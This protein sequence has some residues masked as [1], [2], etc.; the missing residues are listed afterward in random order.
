MLSRSPGKFTAK[1][2]YPAPGGA[3][4]QW[5]IAIYATPVL[6]PGQARAGAC[7][8]DLQVLAGPPRD[9]DPGDV[10]FVFWAL[11]ISFVDEQGTVVGGGHFGLQWFTAG[12]RTR[13]GVVN[14][15]VYD[16]LIGDY[17]VFR[18]S[19]PT[20]PAFVDIGVPPSWGVDYE[21]GDWCRF[22]CFRSPRQDWSGAELDVGERQPGRSHHQDQGRDETAFR[23]TFENLTAGA[24]PVVFRDVL[25]RGAASIRP[26][27]YPVLWTETSHDV[28]ARG[29][30][31]RFA[32]LWW[33]GPDAIQ[34]VRVSYAEG[35]RETE[36]SVD[37]DGAI[38][39]AGGHPRHTP[40]GTELDLTPSRSA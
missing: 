19:V 6:P 14:W 31:A 10:S 23:V 4:P 28:L 17:A 20:D 29:T 18:G 36:C 7:G 12:S 27:A 40:A 39:Q 35:T 11:Q 3:V 22:R 33:D 37:R 24:P 1:V 5:R 9:R 15:G 8:V 2:I 13:F 16:D 32:N 25:V 26:L 34:R 30:I 21:Y 38:V